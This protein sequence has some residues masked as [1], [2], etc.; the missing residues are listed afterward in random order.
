MEKMNINK[1]LPTTGEKITF[2][3]S[4]S[5]RETEG[6]FREA[7]KNSNALGYFVEADN[8]EYTVWKKNSPRKNEVDV[9][10]KTIKGNNKNL[11]TIL[12]L[13]L[14]LFQSC[15]NNNK[16]ISTISY[17]I[18][19]K[20]YKEVYTRAYGDERFDDCE[21]LINVTYGVTF[22]GDT[23]ELNTELRKCWYRKS[24]FNFK[25]EEP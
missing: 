17:K 2:V 11:F 3:I 6:Y 7:S 19:I 22:K 16:K 1:N 15:G 21:D 20:Q 13:V 8:N 14:M 10:F 12:V 23:V 24:S 18:D 25:S 5:G 9:W 4:S